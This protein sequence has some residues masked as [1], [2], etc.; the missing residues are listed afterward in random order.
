MT[1]KVYWQIDSGALPAR[2]EPALRPAWPE[3]LR[4]GR[5]PRSN[6]SHYY[7]QIGRAA[8]NAGFDGL[9]L[10][11]RPEGD[12]SQILAASLARHVPSLLL[13]PEFPASIGSAVY[14]AKEAVSFQ[15]A[16]GGRLGWAVAPDRPAELRAAEGDNVPDAAT[17]ARLEE[18]LTVARGVHATPGFTF[19]G[20]FFEVLNGGFEGPLRS[21]AFPP[22][23]LSGDSEAGI[24]RSARRADVHLFGER[25]ADR[26]TA[27]LALLREA[28]REAGR[29]V[30]AAQKITVTARE[31]EDDLPDLPE[32]GL[33]GTYDHVAE[34]LAE[35]ALAGIDHLILAAEPGL[36]EA[37]RIGQHVL[38]RLRAILHARQ[39]AA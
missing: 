34:S 17:D 11:Y 19:K 7:G 18:F 4:D 3:H 16:T 27:P 9:L 29:T 22:V 15:R 5:S 38:P 36:E 6:R 1:V 23:F 32:G 8:A 28:A 26:L 30:A 33:R 2:A 31:T 14:A 24:R 21:V 20:A 25:D 12:D 37:Y 39:I 35:R 10:A 13:I